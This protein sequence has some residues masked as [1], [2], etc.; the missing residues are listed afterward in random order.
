MFA[1]S[2][3]AIVLSTAVATLASCLTV[4]AWTEFDW[5]TLGLGMMIPLFILPAMIGYALTSLI[6]RLRPWRNAAYFMGVVP[7]I[8]GMLWAAFTAPEGRELAMLFVNGLVVASIAA[9]FALRH[10][11]YLKSTIPLT[12]N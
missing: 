5:E 9:F 4:L 1:K 6:P 10:S 12:V 11:R 8:A 3:A 7:W 2:V